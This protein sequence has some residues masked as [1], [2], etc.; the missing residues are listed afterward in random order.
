MTDHDSTLGAALRER[1]SDEQPDLDELVRLSSRS[2]ARIRRRRRV[3]AVLAGTA[4]V[5]AVVVGVAALQGSDPVAGDQA[6]IA[7][8]PTP[9]PP[10]PTES[11]VLPKGAAPVS[12]DAPGWTCN[13]PMDEKFMCGKDDAWVV[14]NWR[15]A[16]D[17]DAYLDPGKADSLD[18][19]HT[20]VSGVH[21]EWFAT[22]APAKGTTQAEV[23]EVGNGLVWV[24]EVS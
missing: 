8:D 5:A 14:V 12:V 10:P 6:P 16:A 2:G 13:R 24:P 18:G 19:V 11:P 9:T 7:S 17:H 21:G 23:D 4:G 22:V 3:G 20:F 1:V 15:E